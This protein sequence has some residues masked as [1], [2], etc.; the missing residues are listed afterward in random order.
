[1]TINETNIVVRL[2]Y[3]VLGIVIGVRILE[4]TIILVGKIFPII[5]VEIITE[6]IITALV[7]IKIILVIRI[8]IKLVLLIRYI[9]IH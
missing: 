2:L 5:V 8:L 6:V 7:L 4:V 3:L 1:M 9:K